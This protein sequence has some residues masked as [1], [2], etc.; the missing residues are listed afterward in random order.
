MDSATEWV[1]DGG[2]AAKRS[3]ARSHSSPSALSHC[4]ETGGLVVV[5]DACRLSIWPTAS[6]FAVLPTAAA[7]AAAAL[8][9]LSALHPTTRAPCNPYMLPLSS[10]VLSRLVHRI[11]VW[12]MFHGR[13][14]L[15]KK[16]E[17]NGA[18]ICAAVYESFITRV[19]RCPYNRSATSNYHCVV[20][21]TYLACLLVCSLCCN[22]KYTQHLKNLLKCKKN[23]YQ[24]YCLASYILLIAWRSVSSC[25]TANI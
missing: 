23:K 18:V 22:L 6:S 25:F 16:V 7:A 15:S 19:S 5:I 14:Y 4:H 20:S 3:A 2:H 13:F 21:L 24:I 8:W 11:T 9:P 12:I 1:S 10:F 17:L